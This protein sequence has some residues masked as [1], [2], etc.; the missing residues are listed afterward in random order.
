ML[1]LT[2]ADLRVKAKSWHRLKSHLSAAI[3][4]RVFA[5]NSLA[6]QS[7]S[8]LAILLVGPLADRLLEPAMMPGEWLTK[9]LPGF[10]S[11]P[12]A[13]MHG[14]CAGHGAGGHR[15]FLAAQRA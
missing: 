15:R 2:W 13:S 12:S 1:F 8:A 3:Q 10:G 7:V 4:G 14:L 9:R 5:A 6:S 11:G